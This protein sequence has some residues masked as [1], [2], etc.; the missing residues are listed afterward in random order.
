MWPDSHLIAK[1]RIEDLYEKHH[2]SNKK[3]NTNGEK[4]RRIEY[5][6]NRSMKISFLKGCEIVIAFDCDYNTYTHYAHTID[7]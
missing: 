3:N 2:I 5:S 4:R 7:S 6:G 1:Q